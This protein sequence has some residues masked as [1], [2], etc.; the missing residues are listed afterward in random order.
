MQLWCDII[1]TK[2]WWLHP[3][4]CRQQTVALHVSSSVESFC[5]ES[6]Q[7]CLRMTFRPILG[8]Y[9]GFIWKATDRHL[10]EL[11]V[12]LIFVTVHSLFERTAYTIQLKI[13][14]HE[15]INLKKNHTKIWE[16]KNTTQ[17][18][19]LK[20]SQSKCWWFLVAYLVSNWML[21]IFFHLF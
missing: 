6:F 8:L 20:E 13:D 10:F 5:V 15:Q 14:K 9:T 1:W 3:C 17:L 21:S 11:I 16:W 4:S 18:I 12:S 2:L 7:R 19:Y